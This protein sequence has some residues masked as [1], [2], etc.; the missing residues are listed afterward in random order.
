MN[1]AWYIA[2][3]FGV[4]AGVSYVQRNRARVR[5]HRAWV[6]TQGMTREQEQTEA[7]RWC[8]TVPPGT[9]FTGGEVR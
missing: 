6:P 9:L 2:G 3:L 7:E 4:F 5:C 8:G 1:V